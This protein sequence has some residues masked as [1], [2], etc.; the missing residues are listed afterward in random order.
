MFI[1]RRQ[2]AKQLLISS[3]ILLYV[4]KILFYVN[5]IRC[6]YYI[7]F[8]HANKIFMVFITYYLLTES[9]VITEK[10]QTEALMY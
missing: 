6:R 10:S 3:A 7:K 1:Q 8:S 2:S 4:N 5:K 9:K